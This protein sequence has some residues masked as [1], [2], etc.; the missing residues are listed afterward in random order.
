ME[1]RFYIGQKVSFKSHPEMKIINNNVRIP[2]DGEK[3]TIMCLLEDHGS[4][5]KWIVCEYPE[6]F[7]G[8]GLLKPIMD[9]S[10]SFAEEVLEKIAITV[11]KEMQNY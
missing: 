1:N 8:N 10:I 11:E 6:R 2:V 3:L 4:F 7:I 5:E 9:D